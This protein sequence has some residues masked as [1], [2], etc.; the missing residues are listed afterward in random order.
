MRH[1]EGLPGR[2]CPGRAAEP[3]AGLRHVP[4][5]RVTVSVL[6][7]G[8][9]RRAAKTVMAAAV[10]EAL[11]FGNDEFDF[12]PDRARSCCGSPTTPH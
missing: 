5:L 6:A 10:I 11:F 7:H 9:D 3:G 4:P 8:D 12:E 2:G 1:T